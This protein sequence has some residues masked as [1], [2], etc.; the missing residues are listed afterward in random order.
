MKKTQN[1]TLAAMMIAIIA[2]CAQLMIP[3]GAVQFSMQVFAVFLAAAL[4]SPAWSA[5][6]MLAYLLLGAVGAPVFGG[7]RGGP[8]V[9][10]GVTG[11]FI[12]AF[13]LMAGYISLMVKRLHVASFLPLFLVLASSL[14]IC[15]PVGCLW[16]AAIADAPIAKAVTVAVLPFIVPDLLKAALA[17]WLTIRL[18]KVIR[19]NPR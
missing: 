13:P 16:F 10:F 6:A 17:A 9:L 2:V 14:L 8:G 11:G 19:Q 3:F 15:Y 5:G 1:L 4:L 18:K 12:I 7:F